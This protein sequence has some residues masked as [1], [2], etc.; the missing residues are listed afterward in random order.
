[1]AGHEIQERL[2]FELSPG[3]LGDARI[4]NADPPL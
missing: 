2:V 3:L 4:K 1:M